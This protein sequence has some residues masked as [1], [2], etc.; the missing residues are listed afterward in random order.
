MRRPTR[1]QWCII[2]PTLLVSAHIWLELDASAILPPRSVSKKAPRAQKPEVVDGMRM[3]AA[4]R[5]LGKGWTAVP[6]PDYDAPARQ[7]GAIES[8]PPAAE[9][10]RAWGLP[11]Y[12]RPALENHRTALAFTVLLMGGLLAWQVS[13][14]KSPK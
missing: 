3:E 1:L 9:Q 7:N 12:L 13:G 2:W 8:A 5:D 10:Q 14:K 4:P 11:G 6:A